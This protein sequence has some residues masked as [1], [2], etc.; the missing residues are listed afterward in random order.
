MGITFGSVGDII[1]VS[2]LVK[3][4]LLALDSSRG[5]S[6]EY[7]AIVRELYV[8]DTALLQVEQLSRTQSGT[9]ELQA[10]YDTAKRTVAKCRVSLDAFTKRIAK[11]ESS[12]A[13]SGSGSIIKDTARKLQWRASQKEAELV[14][15]RAEVTGYTDSI[16]M[17]IATVQML[18]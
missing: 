13:A 10:L 1:S 15:F 11:Y 17:L 7:Q 12:L 3:D 2:L 5:S 6:S 16:N 18:V 8:L 9:L 14:K 4:L